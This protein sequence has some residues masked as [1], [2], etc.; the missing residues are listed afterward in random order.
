MRAAGIALMLLGSLAILEGLA[1]VI[2]VPAS[3]DLGR[4]RSYEARAAALVAGPRPRVALIG[5]SATERG[6]DVGLLRRAWEARTGEPLSVDMFVADGSA[7]GTWYWIVAKEFW[8]PGRHPDLLIVTYY[9]ARLTDSEIIEIG[10]IARYF[11]DTEDRAEL[12]RRDFTTLQQRVDYLISS[13]S[14]AWAVRDRI[15]ERVLTLIPGYEKFATATNA[16]NFQEEKPGVPTGRSP[17]S[18]YENLRRFLNRARAEGTQ[19]CFVA[20]PTRPARIGSSPYDLAPEAL[21]AIADAGMLHLDLRHVD[22]LSPASYQD[23][24]HLNAQGRSVYSAHLAGTLAALSPLGLD[25]PT[26]D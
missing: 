18:T 11:S 5:N 2:L 4:F 13:R 12:F 3:L 22:G 25:K 1:R 21:E 9:D 26:A 14:Q 24:V 15:R 10:R 7:I 19:V 20:F 8:K 23:R 16:I 17:S 6:V